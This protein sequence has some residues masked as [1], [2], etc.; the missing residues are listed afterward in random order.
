M[1]LPN[2][3]ITPEFLVQLKELVNADINPVRYLSIDPGKSNGVC[4]YDAKFYLAL[5]MLTVQEDDMIE[6]LDQ[7]EHIDTCI[8][9]DFVLYPNKS[10]EQQYSDMETSRVIGRIEAWAKHKNVKLV[11]QLASVKKNGY[12]WAGKKPLPKSNPLNHALDA[13]IHFI[14]WAVRTRK[15]NAA[16]LLGMK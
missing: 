6:L 5:P 4:A 8:V 15:I 3:K 16:D 7:F 14:Y 10:T 12:M 2:G 1:L 9:E 13:H 11:K